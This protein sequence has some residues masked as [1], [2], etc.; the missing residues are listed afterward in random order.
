MITVI[1]QTEKLKNLV[2]PQ[3]ETAY[4]FFTSS[5]SKAQK[6]NA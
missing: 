1:P 4:I 2:V 6:C 5:N 3:K